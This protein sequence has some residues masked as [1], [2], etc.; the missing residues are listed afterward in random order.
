MRKTARAATCAKY[1]CEYW[2]SAAYPRGEEGGDVDGGVHV[3]LLEL[4]LADDRPAPAAH[5][6]ARGLERAAGRLARGQLRQG[7]RGPAAWQ[8]QAASAGQKLRAPGRRDA[9]RVTRTV[10]NSVASRDSA[11]TRLGLLAD[12]EQVLNARY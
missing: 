4:P 3:G 1:D 5:R 9:H 6:R 7:V 2:C 12:P 10:A 11:T 8:G